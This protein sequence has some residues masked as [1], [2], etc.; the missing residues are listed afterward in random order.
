MHERIW[1]FRLTDENVIECSSYFRKR[2]TEVA[3]DVNCQLIASTVV[4]IE[5]RRDNVRK[6]VGTALLQNAGENVLEFRPDPKRQR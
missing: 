1:K 4:R 3:A 5:R 2:A 6:I